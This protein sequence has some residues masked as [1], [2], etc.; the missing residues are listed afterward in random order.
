M[1]WMLL[2]GAGAAIAWLTWPAPEAAH[3]STPLATQPA[4]TEPAPAPG[5]AGAMSFF[6]P[7]ASTAS[8]LPAAV[9][10]RE[11]RLHGD[12]E[13]PPIAR[14]PMTREQPSALELA[15]P[16]AYQAYE[17]RQTQRVYAAYVR[18]VDEEL[19]RLMNDIARGRAMG[20]APEEIAKAEEKARQLEKMRASLAQELEAAH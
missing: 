7:L 6:S 14:D 16:K 3:G 13:A 2:A 17:A 11:T 15:D 12:P 8:A 18:A 20:I 5:G 9:S 1:K 4:A 10:M 19:P